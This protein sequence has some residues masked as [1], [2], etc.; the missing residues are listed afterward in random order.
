MIFFSD[1][2]EIKSNDD[3]IFDMKFNAR[4]SLQEIFGVA[5]FNNMDSILQEYLIQT[6]LFLQLNT[7][8]YSGD[9]SI[10]ALMCITNLYAAAECAFRPLIEENHEIFTSIEAIEEKTKKAGF[11]NLPVALK[12]IRPDLLQ[13]TLDGNDQTLGASVVVWL[14]QANPDDL[15]QIFVRI[16]LFLAD[17]SRLLTLRGHG[18][19]I[20]K[21]RKSDLRQI[22]T[23]IYKI[24]DTIKEN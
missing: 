16:P 22:C 11:G 4:R 15:E 5:Q 14:L 20:C 21:I 8:E 7:K 18:N 17:I 12:T 23:S 24:I 6:E 13:K 9:E 19:Q 1:S 2:K 3:T 10:D